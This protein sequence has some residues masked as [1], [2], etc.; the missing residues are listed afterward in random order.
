MVQ[1][2]R[3]YQI[4][5]GKKKIIIE[6]PNSSNRIFFSVRVIAGEASW[7]DV[8]MS[9]DDPLFLYYILNGPSKYFEAEG[10]D[11]FQGNVWIFNDT[12]TDLFVTTT[13]ILS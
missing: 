13:E 8:K 9:F 10:K 6:K 5:A 11:I 1:T 3:S 12:D 4:L 7:Y 2:L